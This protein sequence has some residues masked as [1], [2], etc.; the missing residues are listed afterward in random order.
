MAHRGSRFVRREKMTMLNFFRKKEWPEI[1]FEEIKKRSKILVVDDSD[2]AYLSLFKKDGYSIEHWKDI[3]SLPSLEKG[4]FDIIL[5]DIQGVG[6]KQSAQDQGF[7]ILKHLHQVCPAQIVVAYSNADWSLKYQEFFRMADAVLAKSS[8]YV[9]FKR[10]VDELLRKR[11]S[12]SFYLDRFV[13]LTGSHTQGDIAKLKKQA[14]NA[15]LSRSTNKL[16]DYLKSEID[17]SKAVSLGIEVIKA[18][19]SISIM[20]ATANG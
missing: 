6:K 5:L 14:T 1:P 4:D 13:Q 3:K 18:A 8:D 2:F 19:I 11:F 12:M 17:N 15:I 20:I 9:D 10:V 7:G 16:E